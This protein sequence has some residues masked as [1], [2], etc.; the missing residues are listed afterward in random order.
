[1]ARQDARAKIDD[2]EYN[3]TQLDPRRAARVYLFLTSR[4]GGTLGKAIGAVKG[5]KGLMDADVNMKDLG[6]ALE[7][8]FLSLD[9]ERMVEHIDTLLSSV[10]F[11]AT[12]MSLD[13]NNFQGAMLHMTKVVKKAVEVN[14][15]DFLGESSGV[16]AKFREMFRRM[17]QEKP[18]STGSSGDPS[19]RALQP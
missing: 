10:I 5:G 8:L 17:S 19:L 4:V 6:E 14:F 12:N 9:D 2:K 11:G 3:F 15:S 1:M 7:T 16:A 13:H 18:T